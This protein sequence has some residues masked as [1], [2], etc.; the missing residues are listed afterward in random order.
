MSK[1]CFDG[2]TR[3]KYISRF[4]LVVMIIT[5]LESLLKTGKGCWN[6]KSL[7]KNIIASLIYMLLLIVYCQK[8]IIKGNTIDIREIERLIS[9]YQL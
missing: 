1:N 7:F 9:L 5:T 6:S 8:P 2:V 4:N 3:I